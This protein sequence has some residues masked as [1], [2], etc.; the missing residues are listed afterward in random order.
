MD[1]QNHLFDLLLALLDLL[2]NLAIGLLIGNQIA[3]TDAES[4][5]DE[6]VLHCI[7]KGIQQIHG[8]LRTMIVIRHM[9]DTF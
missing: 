2:L 5:Q 1:L 9:N 4:V 3:D 8:V 6:E 7:L